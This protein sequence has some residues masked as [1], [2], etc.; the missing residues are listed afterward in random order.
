MATAT[1]RAD[2]HVQ[3]FYDGPDDDSD[4]DP[5]ADVPA[6]APAAATFTV[7][8]LIAGRLFVIDDPSPGPRPV[9]T[10]RPGGELVCSRPGCGALCPHIRRVLETGGVG[11]AEGGPDG[12]VP[13]TTSYADIAAFEFDCRPAR[14]AA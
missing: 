12:R 14:S 1:L 2:E 13:A 6:P 9:V 7:R 10:V 4:F 5:F 3:R 8:A 11:T